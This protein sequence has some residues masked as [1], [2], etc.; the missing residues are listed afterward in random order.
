MRR[1]VISDTH[2]AHTNIIKYCDRPFSS[3]EEMDETMIANWNSVVTPDDFVYHL[4]DFAFGRGSKE[5][6]E[7]YA[8]RLN[9][10]IILIRGNH[11]RETNGWYERKG[12]WSVYGGEFFHYPM[13]DKVLL[14]H[15]PYPTK[16][17]YINIYGHIHNLFEITSPNYKCVCVEKLNY[18]PIDLDELIKEIKHGIQGN[19]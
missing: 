18:T 16:L 10:R 13:D 19:T 8:R 7:P 17:P 14:S 11:D 2:F 15:R 12:F 6:I 5:L 3:A 1:F 4:G 9:G